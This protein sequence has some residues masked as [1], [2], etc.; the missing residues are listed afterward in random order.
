MES[1][2]R[3][4][5]QRWQRSKCKLQESLLR[6]SAEHKAQRLKKEDGLRLKVS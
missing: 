3:A 4:L 1:R 2:L 5:E 6:S